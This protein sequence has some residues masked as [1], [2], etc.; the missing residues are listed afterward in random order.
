MIP[1]PF[2]ETAVL[3]CAILIA[4]ACSSSTPASFQLTNA[5]VDPQSYTCPRGSTDAPYDLHVTMHARNDTAKEVIV[6]SASAAMVLTAVKGSWLERA[7]DRYDAGTVAVSPANIAAKSS[8][9]LD[10]SIRSACTSGASTPTSSGTYQVS[11]HLVTSAGEFVI[12][13]ANKHQILAG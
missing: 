1:R 3:V 5:T 4:A 2:V 10:V 12:T 6:E 7:G 8:A 9:T 11:V 13:A